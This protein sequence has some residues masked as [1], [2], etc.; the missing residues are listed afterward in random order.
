MS[1]PTPAIAPAREG[2]QWVLVSLRLFRA[3]W[4]RYT[5]LA[6]AFL[7]AMQI[8]SVL[9]G[10]LAVMLLKPILTVGFLAAAWHHERG[11][12]PK[13]SHLLAGFKSNWRALL[14][15]G[16][17]YLV[18][19][20]LA[21]AL[22][23]AFTGIDLEAI[24]QGKGPELNDPAVTRF[25]LTTIVLTLPVTA[26]LWFA[27]ALIVFAD[28]SLVESVK[29]SARAWLKNLAPMIVYGLTLMGLLFLAAL[30]ASPF[31]MWL[32]ES[33]TTL[34]VM[35]LALPVTAVVMISDYVSYRAIFHRHESLRRVEPR[36]E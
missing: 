3:Q 2:S 13:L 27:P 11:D 21:A 22:A 14:P 26:A 6:A 12:L 33:R 15:L 10:G 30:A 32:G 9:T 19:V 18:G 8:A 35:L 24:M 5:S 31:M 34:I 20:M 1:I 17:I 7:L 25:M 4:L 36:V 29:H 23:T 28:A 16:V